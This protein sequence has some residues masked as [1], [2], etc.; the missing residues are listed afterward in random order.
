MHESTGR[1]VAGRYRIRS[2]IGRGGM[3]RVW[4]AD[5]EVLDRQVAVKQLLPGASGVAPRTARVRALAEARA[6]AR[7]GHVGVVTVH[8]VVKDG[9]Q[10]WIVM[11]VLSGRTLA[12]AIRAD[13]PLPVAEVIRI[14][15]GLVEGLRVV[16]Q[17]GVVHR[18]VTP[19]NVHLCADGRVVLTDFGIARTHDTTLPGDVLACSPAH[20]SPEQLAGQEP[21][22]A[23]DM[24]SLGSTLFAAVEG[25]APFD[26]GNLIATFAAI[27]ADAPVLSHRAEP[28]R[29]VIEGLLAKDPERRSTADQAHAA[30]TALPARSHRHPS[31]KAAPARPC[32]VD[33]GHP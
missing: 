10:L 17:A 32:R 15:L 27:A 20:V 16:H 3:G 19:A 4:L 18:D 8:D 21:G 7:V 12:E 5:D 31:R 9:G 30:L 11:E 25:V 26:R 28:L 14:G 13:G 1:L 24:F 33:P 23:A 29:A 6:A 2:L 22:A